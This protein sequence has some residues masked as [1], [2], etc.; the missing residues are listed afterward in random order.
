MSRASAARKAA[1]KAYPHKQGGPPAV[2]AKAPAGPP[3]SDAEIAKLLGV[4]PVEDALGAELH[5]HLL[6]RYQ[7]CVFLRGH[8][9]MHLTA[10]G[11]RGPG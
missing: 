2:A 3:I 4:D 11:S 8:R 9:F 6:Q 5:R 1:R 7:R 10:R